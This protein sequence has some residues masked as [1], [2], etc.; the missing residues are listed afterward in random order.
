MSEKARLSPNPA[1]LRELLAGENEFRPPREILAGLTGAQACAR[2]PAAPHSIAELVCHLLFW[3]DRRS[4]FARGE[5]PPWE[6]VEA[7]DWRSVAPEEWDELRQRFLEGL[8]AFAAHAADPAA[9]AKDLPYGRNFGLALASQTLHNA[10]HLGQVILLRQLL[11][12]WPPPQ[13]S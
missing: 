8:D 7:G 11:G 3:Q 2:L 10:H 13:E 1:A 9:L 12:C 5:E 4:A 6:E